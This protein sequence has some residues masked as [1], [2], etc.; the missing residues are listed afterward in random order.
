ML[1]SQDPPGIRCFRPN[2]RIDIRSARSRLRHIGALRVLVA[3]FV[4]E[5]TWSL[6][7]SLA[8]GLGGQ[9]PP[10]D[11]FAWLWLGGA[12][13]L[14]VITGIAALLGSPPPERP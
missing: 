3:G 12:V 2:S 9:P 8:F 4:A 6:I 1:R 11:A 7:G 13:V 14:A 5:L 10:D